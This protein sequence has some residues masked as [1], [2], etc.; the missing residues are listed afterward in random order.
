VGT[1]FENK[2]LK[3]RWKGREGEEKDFSSYWIASG[4]V[5]ILEI[6]TGNT[7]SRFSE[8]SIWKSLWT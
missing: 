2:L 8:N 5:K 1:V 3:K 4:R 7:K 6:E